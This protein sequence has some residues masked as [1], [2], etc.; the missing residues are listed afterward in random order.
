M[1][2]IIIIA[3]IA[4]GGFFALRA[5]IKRKG[6]CG[7]CDGHCGCCKKSDKKLR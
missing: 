2:D 1:T 6:S 5:V 4:A 7:C 3:L